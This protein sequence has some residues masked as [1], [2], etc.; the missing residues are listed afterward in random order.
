[1]TYILRPDGA[2][3]M[4]GHSLAPA[5]AVLAGARIGVLDN[6]KPNAGLLMTTIAAHLATRAGASQP[7]VLEKN[8]AHAAPDEHI[9]R[10]A[11]E[12]DLVLTGSAD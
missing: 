11:K 10:L 7:L 6:L 3:A 5:R 1:M 4:P 9:E 12:V 8:A 2:I